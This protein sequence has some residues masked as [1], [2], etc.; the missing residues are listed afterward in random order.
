MKSCAPLSPALAMIVLIVLSIAIAGCSEGVVSYDILV[1]KF[2]AGGHTAWSTKIGS[3]NQ[4]L[5]T[6]VTDTPDAGYA[7]AGLVADSP[8][9]TAYPRVVRLDPD[10][11]VL[12]DRTL[13]LS[14]VYSVAITG[15]PDGGFV[16]AQNINNFDSGKVSKIDA[17]GQPVWNRT[18]DSALRAIIPARDG[19]FVLAG[20]RTFYIDANGT[21]LWNRSFSSTSIRE[22][23]GGGFIAERSGV[24]YPDTSV[25]YLDNNGTV[26]WTTP[27]G[28]RESGKITSLFEDPTRDIEAVYTFYDSTKNKDV[29]MYM[30]SEQVTLGR[31]GDITGRQPIVAVDPLTRTTD[32]GY[33]FLAYPFPGSSAFTTLP[34]SGSSLHFIRL[35]PGGAVAWDQSLGLSPAATPVSI[36]QTRDGGYLTVVLVPS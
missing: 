3:G 27:V 10:G 12:W 17:D 31:G 34:H 4:N 30:E 25:F 22:A 26:V 2:D 36:L 29:V 18:I 33:A 35:S 8:R 23:A 15:A 19:G 21:I 5:A 1:T 32:G 11:R 16:V 24:P 9:A 7:V 20:S 28:S 6:A 13:D 14:D